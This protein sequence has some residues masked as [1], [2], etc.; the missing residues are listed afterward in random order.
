MIVLVSRTILTTSRAKGVNTT[1]PVSMVS[2]TQTGL[3]PT[4]LSLMTS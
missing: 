4:D 3:V 2:Y 1:S